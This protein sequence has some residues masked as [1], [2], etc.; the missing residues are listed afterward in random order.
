MALQ[1]RLW[2]P[3]CNRCRCALPASLIPSRTQTSVVRNFGTK[4]FPLSPTWPSDSKNVVYSWRES[5]SFRGLSLKFSLSFASR[6]ENRV[7]LARARL[8][9]VS[10]TDE[11]GVRMTDPSILSGESDDKTVKKLPGSNIVITGADVGRLAQVKQAEFIKSSSKESECPSEGHPEIALVGRSNVGK[12]SLINAMV[13]RK[14]LAQTSK[15]PGTF[16]IT[17]FWRRSSLVSSSHILKDQHEADGE[18]NGLLLTCKFLRV[19]TCE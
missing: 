13:K 2:L 18:V 1:H 17:S 5:S 11:V 3:A 16:F 6:A 7:E 10:F 8:S 12:S 15:K 14:E 4:S 9:E 19:E